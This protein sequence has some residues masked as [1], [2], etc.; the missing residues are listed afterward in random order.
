MAST[1]ENIFFE[2]EIRMKIGTVTYIVTAHYDD[3]RE[4]LPEKIRRLLCS[5]VDKQIAH[6]QNPCR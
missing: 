1:T 5:E 2:P 4:N 3:T 6:L